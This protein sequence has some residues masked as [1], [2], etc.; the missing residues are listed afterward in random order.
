[1]GAY[2]MG[3][4]GDTI[5]HCSLAVQHDKLLHDKPFFAVFVCFLCSHIWKIVVCLRKP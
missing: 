3:A 5:G 1:M 2:G 4:V